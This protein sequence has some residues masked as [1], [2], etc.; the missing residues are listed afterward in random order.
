M[1]FEWDVEM[2][3]KHEISSKKPLNTSLSS[4]MAQSS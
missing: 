4:V 1:E 2:V 3:K